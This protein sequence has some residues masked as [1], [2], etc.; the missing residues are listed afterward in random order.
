MGLVCGCWV[1][2]YRSANHSA[3]TGQL[4]LDQ[5]AVVAAGHEW[6]Y[7]YADG[8]DL[9]RMRNEALER[10][11]ESGMHYLGMVDTDVFAT[12]QESPY[13]RLLATAQETGAAMVGAVVGLRKIRRNTAYVNTYPFCPG[14]VFDAT[15]VGTG[16]VL[17]DVEQIDNIAKTYTGPWFARTY[18]DERQSIAKV[19][20]DVFFCQVLTAHG[21]RVVVD[22][23]IP[24]THSYLDSVHLAY[25]GRSPEQPADEATT[26]ESGEDA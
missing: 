4:M 10:A 22:G 24:T 3:L 5:S 21:L 19:G 17:I 6:R 20:E 18:E 16:M 9:P 14:E 12:D 7:W 8:S 25:T 11:R 23:R 15:K 13:M 1:P 26:A 2:A